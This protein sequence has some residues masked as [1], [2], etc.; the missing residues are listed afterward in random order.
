MITKGNILVTG[1]AGFI[2]SHTVVELINQGFGVVIADD[3]SNSHEEVTDAI[4][5]I[6]G[7]RPGCLRI[8][9]C[10]THNTRVLFDGN[11]FDAV[12]HFAAKKLV[13]ESV[14]QPLLYYSNNILSLMN[15]VDA[16]IQTG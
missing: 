8:D 16:A 1:G 9:L 11:K 14:E 2:G 15:V 10:D 3:F 4:T 5:A 12:I 7:T 6:T 13:G